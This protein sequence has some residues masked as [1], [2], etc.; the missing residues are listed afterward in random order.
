[1]INLIPPEGHKVIKREYVYHVIATLSFLFGGVV[2][3]LGVAHIPT[4]VLVG[5][6]IHSM[7]LSSEKERTEEQIL[8]TVAHEISDVAKILI[9][10]K[11]TDEAI[12]SSHVISTLE[13]SAPDGISFKTFSVQEVK[14]RID[15]IQVQG[16]ATTRETLVSFKRTV[17][18][19]ELFAEANV[20]I[21]DLARDINLPFTLTV[22]VAP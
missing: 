1:M 10:L 14:G 11:G 12:S 22:T 20:P 9:Q 15:S 16:I 13:L 4:Y 17:E 5:A 7:T 19:T 3:I 21:A 6:Q 8:T 2:I 18:E